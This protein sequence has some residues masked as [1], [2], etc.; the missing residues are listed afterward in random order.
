MKEIKLPL[1]IGWK[2]RG[3]GHGDYAVLDSNNKPVIAPLNY[4]LDAEFICKAVN[5]HD[6]LI[7]NF[8]G[9]IEQLEKWA[10]E[11]ESGG[12]STHQVKPMRDKANYLKTSKQK[13]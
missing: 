12:W 4:K 2:D 8:K 13:N 7:E 3:M 9:E 6:E 1:S 11:S 10:N 5:N